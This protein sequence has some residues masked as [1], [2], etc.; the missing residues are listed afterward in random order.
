MIYKFAKRQSK[1]TL[2]EIV[3][4]LK[5]EQEVKKHKEEIF[6][7]VKNF[8][9]SK[10]SQKTGISINELHDE[11]TLQQIRKDIE[12]KPV[13]A[14]RTTIGG[15]YSPLSPRK[16][17]NLYEVKKRSERVGKWLRAH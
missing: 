14:T 12:S 6:Q 1:K 17:I 13:K 2:S 9:L 15:H 7:D 8:C 5:N 10:L 11:E 4:L 16:I 3:K